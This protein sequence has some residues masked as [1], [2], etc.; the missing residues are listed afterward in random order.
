MKPFGDPVLDLTHVPVPLGGT[1]EGRISLGSG[2]TTAPDFNLKLQCIRRVLQQGG[3]N[4]HWVETILWSGEHTASLQI[5]GI[6]PVLMVV[7]PDQEK[8]SL[9]RDAFN[10]ILWRLT[11]MAPFRGPAFLE[12]YEIPVEGRTSAAQKIAERESADRRATADQKSAFQS[13]T[14][15]FDRWPRNFCRRH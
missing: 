2:L 7:P 11:V 12:K 5:G 14:A 13:H 9:T 6:V 3:K 15:V 8:R 10:Q 1:L 4:S